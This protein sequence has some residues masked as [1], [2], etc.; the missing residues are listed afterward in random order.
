[1][2]TALYKILPKI[3]S[4]MIN[5]FTICIIWVNHHRL[6]E[7]IKSFNNTL[8][9]LNANLILWVCFIPFPTALIRDYPNN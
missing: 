6:F 2:I 9:W 1:M 4:W 8:F 7:T 3:V 5:F